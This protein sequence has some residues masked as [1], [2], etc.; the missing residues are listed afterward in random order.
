M[1]NE[2]K[3]NLNRNEAKGK[4]VETTQ[5]RE[6]N[7]LFRNVKIKIKETNTEKIE[8]KNKERENWV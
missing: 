6:S 2:T 7:N 5:L 3:S 8:M 1:Y 4:L